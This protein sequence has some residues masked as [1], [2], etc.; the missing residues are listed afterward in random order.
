MQ[1]EPK[2]TITVDDISQIKEVWEKEALFKTI[3]MD[4]N[5][6]YETAT[7]LVSVF[8]QAQHN[9]GKISPH[10]IDNVTRRWNDMITKI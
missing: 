7:F 1:E 6:S 10:A 5:L 9:G 4:A 8:S 3:L 2:Y